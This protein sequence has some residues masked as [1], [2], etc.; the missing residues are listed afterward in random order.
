MS[1]WRKYPKKVDKFRCTNL[2]H[3]WRS[4]IVISD[5]KKSYLSINRET[6]NWKKTPK[7]VPRKREKTYLTS[8]VKSKVPQEILIIF[9]LQK[10]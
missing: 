7:N 4:V 2:N 6:P 9:E 5:R 1:N 10:W 3:E 8:S